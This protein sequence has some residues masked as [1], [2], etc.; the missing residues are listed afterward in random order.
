M[1][2]VYAYILCRSQTILT[3]NKI[4]LFYKNLSVTLINLNIK[5]N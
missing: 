4:P 5:Y 3:K 2:N 1:Y